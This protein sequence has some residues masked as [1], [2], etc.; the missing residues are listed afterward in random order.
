[1]NLLDRIG[2]T[3]FVR[4]VWVPFDRTTIH[5]VLSLTNGDNTEYRELFLQSDYAK[6][7]RKLTVRQTN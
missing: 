2:S 4:G 1:M 5:K 6:I 7:L 3:V